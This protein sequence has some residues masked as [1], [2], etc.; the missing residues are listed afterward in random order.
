MLAPLILGMRLAGEDELDLALGIVDQPVQT[1]G[2][3]EQQIHALVRRESAGDAD[4]QSLRIQSGLLGIV[5][6]FLAGPGPVLPLDASVHVVH[7]MG[8]EFLVLLP[9]LQVVHL[10]HAGPDAWVVHPLPPV[11]AEVLV[12][13]IRH[14][15]GQPGVHVDAVGD[16]VDGDLML[17]QS[18]GQSGCQIALVMRACRAETAFR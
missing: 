15:L 1:G 8:A 17:R 2:V 4:G 11:G 7:E 10:L 6:Q 18:S 16:E 9:E 12:E 3:P 14:G 5:A 13:E